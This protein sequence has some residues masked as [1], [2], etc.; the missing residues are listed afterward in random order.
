M[1]FNFDELRTF[2]EESKFVL[3]IAL[4]FINIGS[5]YVIMDLS[6][7]QQMFFQNT[8]IKRI[9]IFS[10]FFVGTRD[11]KVS[12]ISTLFTVLLADGLLNEKSKLNVLP[13]SL[14]DDEVTIDEYNLAQDL[15]RKYEQ[16]NINK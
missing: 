1:Q 10:I 11:F 6:K 7:S 15:I 14:F 2:T 5:R 12:A 4:L 13:E 8:I 16:S 3:A 9:V